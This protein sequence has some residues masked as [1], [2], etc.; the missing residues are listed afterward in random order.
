VNN[1]GIENK[2]IFH[3]NVSDRMASE[4]S[5]GNIPVYFTL[6]L[7]NQLYDFTGQI[8]PKVIILDSSNESISDNKSDIK[9]DLEN[10]F[11][12][13]FHN[14]IQARFKS[15]VEDIEKEEIRLHTELH[16][17][18]KDLRNREIADIEPEKVNIEVKDEGQNLGNSNNI[19]G[20]CRCCNI[21]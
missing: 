12:T 21:A 5:Q 16:E 18:I 13:S 9:L 4:L 17:N 1:L 7:N 14:H 10:F 20:S 8:V 6:I 3:R 2:S 15:I 19:D 11:P